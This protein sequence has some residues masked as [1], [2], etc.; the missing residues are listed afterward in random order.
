MASHIL[1]RDNTHMSTRDSDTALP[2]TQLT[3]TTFTETLHEVSTTC[4][5]MSVLWSALLEEILEGN[6]CWVGKSEDPP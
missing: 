6:I 3:Q 2:C 5:H 4:E 1:S